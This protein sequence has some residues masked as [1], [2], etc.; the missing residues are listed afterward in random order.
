[1]PSFNMEGDDWWLQRYN[2]QRF[3]ACGDGEVNAGAMLP[4]QFVFDGK[5]NDAEPLLTRGFSLK[6]GSPVSEGRFSNIDVKIE[7]KTPQKVKL[8]FDVEPVCIEERLK[9]APEV[10]FH[11]L[12]NTLMIATFRFENSKRQTIKV[13]AET[14]GADMLHIEFQHLGLLS[15]YDLLTWQ[16]SPW[17]DARLP[18]FW[19][20][21]IS[22]ADAM[23]PTSAVNVLSRVD[24]SIMSFDYDGKRFSFLVDEFND[25][26]QSFHANGRF[27]ELDGL[28]AMRTS[29]PQSASILDVGAHVGNHTVFFSSFLNAKRIVPIEPNRRAQA[30]LRINCALNGASNV[31]LSFVDHAL[32]AE[33]AAGRVITEA[34]LNS[35]GTKVEPHSDGGVKIVCGDDIFPT[36]S[37]DLI[38]IDVQG[39]EIDALKGLA[40]LIARC[41]PILFVGVTKANTRSFLKQMDKFGYQICYKSQMYPELT[42]YKAR[43]RS[44]RRQRFLRF[45]HGR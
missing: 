37:F 19:L 39:M 32:G 36:E 34:G 5:L 3:P 18:N 21:S 10:G 17:F 1:M 14:D 38:K 24:G 31:D 15:G 35:G 41:H 2:V 11:L 8:T 44:E 30:S 42:N 43:H 20:H 7:P 28:Q 13:E 26:V 33:S 12:V 4:V 29:A 40:N 45:F 27:Y 25:S 6:N 16:K 9:H 23:E 22:I